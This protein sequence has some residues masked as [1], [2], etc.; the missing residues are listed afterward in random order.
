M[1]VS[2]DNLWQTEYLRWGLIPS[3]SKQGL[4]SKP[5]INARRE[6]LDQKASFKQALAS[7]RCLILA[8]GFYEWNHEL[9]RRNPLFFQLENRPIFAFAGLWEAWQNYDDQMIYSTTI[10]NTAAEGIMKEI[11]PRMPVVLSPQSYHD[12]LA[13]SLTNA[14][15][16]KHLLLNNLGTKFAYY[17]VTEKVNLVKNDY[18]SLIQPEKVTITEQLSLF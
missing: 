13:P 1:I 12:W 16:L 2:K 8:D 6:T 17:P 3:W 10:V 4:K 5:L 15:D 9:Y 14:E 18:P 11:H 7:R